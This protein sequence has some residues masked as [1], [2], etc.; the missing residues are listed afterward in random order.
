MDFNV[1]SMNFILFNAEVEYQEL[2]NG[3]K[4]PMLKYFDVFKSVSLANSNTRKVLS[5]D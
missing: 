3:Q 4:M 5:M 2:P 1:S